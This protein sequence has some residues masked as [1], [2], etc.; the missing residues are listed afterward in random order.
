MTFMAVVQVQCVCVCVCT[1][2]CACMCVRACVLSVNS[3]FPVSIVFDGVSIPTMP[4]V[5]FC[6]VF[7]LTEAL[8]NVVLSCNQHAGVMVTY[9]ATFCICEW[10]SCSDGLLIYL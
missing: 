6:C 3:F 2:A 1:C 7:Q 10:L 8:G 9:S 4:S 5:C